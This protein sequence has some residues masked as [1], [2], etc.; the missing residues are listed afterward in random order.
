[1]QDYRP[2][3]YG[4]CYPEKPWKKKQL[5]TLKPGLQV[6]LEYKSP[7]IPSKVH[8]VGKYAKKDGCCQCVRPANVQ[9]DLAEVR[10]RTYLAIST[11]DNHQRSAESLRRS[12]ERMLNALLVKYRKRLS[13]AGTDKARL[14]LDI[15]VRPE[16]RQDDLAVNSSNHIFCR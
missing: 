4:I 15:Q 5:F 14:V 7:S 3:R 11:P 9:V 16:Q 13:K 8:A 12:L 2:T 1:M 10:P 6:L